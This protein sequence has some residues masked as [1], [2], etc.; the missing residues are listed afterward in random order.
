MFELHT[1]RLG[2]PQNFAVKCV[3]GIW[4]CYAS[5]Q[6]YV[7]YIIGTYLSLLRHACISF[8]CLRSGI[9]II[10]LNLCI[11]CKSPWSTGGQNSR[12]HKKY[13]RNMEIGSDML[14]RQ[15][16][17]T[18]Q[19]KFASSRCTSFVYHDILTRVWH[20]SCSVLHSRTL[21]HVSVPWLCA[22]INWIWEIC[23]DLR[24]TNLVYHSQPCKTRTKLDEI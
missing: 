12:L 17:F 16:K 19:A 2:H 20:S 11:E 9:C 1:A 13:H 18:I 10:N 4:H 7:S 3:R 21:K 15:K 23:L 22:V 6:Y 5:C 24:F 8:Q 14:E